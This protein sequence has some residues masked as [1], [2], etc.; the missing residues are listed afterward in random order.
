[1]GDKKE[2]SLPEDDGV[3]NEDYLKMSAE[4]LEKE[5]PAFYAMMMKHGK[6]KVKDGAD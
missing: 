3:S 5:D 6:K 1:M 4:F 2:K